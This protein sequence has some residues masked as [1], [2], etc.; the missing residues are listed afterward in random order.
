[1]LPA[2]YPIGRVAGKHGF[3]GDLMLHFH[4]ESF[5]ETIHKGDYLFIRLEG[6]GVP[7]LIERFQPKSGIVKL[8]DV[9]N[10]SQASAL[11]GMEI[12]TQTEPED[13]EEG[14]ETLL[15]GYELHLEQG[16]VI[17]TIT[18]VEEYPAGWMLLVNG[19]ANELL[20]PLVEDWIVGIDEAHKLLVMNIPEGLTEL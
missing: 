19:T 17:G 10:E 13:A 9:D 11:E 3:H 5:S 8:A 2:L 12:M 20:I 4:Q 16:N 14:L 7:F 6:K 1:M 15:T 18:A